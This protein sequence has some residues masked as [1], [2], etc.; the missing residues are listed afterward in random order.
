ME[1]H[2]IPNMNWN[3][4]LLVDASGSMRGPKWRLVENTVA[5]I[6]KAFLGFENSFRAYAYFEANGISMVANLVRARNLVS[7]P[8]SGQTTSGQSIIAAAYF[9]PQDGRRRLLIHITDGESNLG[10]P[11]QYG[12]D[13]CRDKGIHLVTLGCGY[14][15]RQAMLRQYGRGIQFLNSF[16][17]LPSALEKLLKWT[18][19]YGG[20]DNHSPSQQNWALDQFDS[21]GGAT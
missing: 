4:C 18:L 20:T 6:H 1:A 12:I 16:G 8:P 15:N 3:I 10:C 2:H 5:T 14:N 11:V 19:I 17:Q 13:F 9:M 7:I 21:Q